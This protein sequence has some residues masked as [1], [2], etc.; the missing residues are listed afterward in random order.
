MTPEK[1]VKKK[2]KTKTTSPK[3][4]KESRAYNFTESDLF[5][6]YPFPDYDLKS[7]VDYD[8]LCFMLKSLGIS[9]NSLERY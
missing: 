5:E 2:Q 6:P 7:S 4:S 1:P 9:P 3:S 8:T